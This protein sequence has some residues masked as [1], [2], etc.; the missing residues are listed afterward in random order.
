MAKEPTNF[1]SKTGP[2]PQ[3]AFENDAISNP[4]PDK[5]PDSLYQRVM[6]RIDEQQKKSKR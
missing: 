3:E 5:G 6:A 1:R 4:E 2:L